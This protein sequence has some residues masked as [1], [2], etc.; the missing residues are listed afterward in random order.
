MVFLNFSEQNRQKSEMIQQER[1]TLMNALSNL[2]Q[3]NAGN[4]VNN[5]KTSLE[6]STAS[7]PEETFHTAAS[8]FDSSG[9]DWSVKAPKGFRVANRL[10]NSS[11][12]TMSPASLG[13]PFASIQETPEPTYENVDGNP[14]HGFNSSSSANFGSDST[15]ITSSS[16]RSPAMLTDYKRLVARLE[17]ENGSNASMTSAGMSS[18][19]GD[20][21]IINS[22]ASSLADSSYISGTP[23]PTMAMDILRRR[24]FNVEM[25]PVNR[26]ATN[27]G[28]NQGRLTV[29][30]TTPLLQFVSGPTIKKGLNIGPPGH[31]PAPRM[32]PRNLFP[33]TQ[34]QD[35][36]KKESQGTPKVEKSKTVRIK[37]TNV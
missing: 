27:T 16:L 15:T 1:L 37:E 21:T 9:S 12:W 29:D 17:A 36:G 4:S 35:E 20:S 7:S 13:T 19:Q 34:G 31:T 22:D 18:S 14:F 8:R 23:S 26:V 10:G 32:V 6:T 11:T 28:N 25:F 2:R 30:M 33:P 24:G 3:G 5:T